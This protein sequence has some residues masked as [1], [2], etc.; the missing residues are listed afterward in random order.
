VY[1]IEHIEVVRR[2]E[3]SFNGQA[4]GLLHRFGASCQV[5]RATVRAVS[6]PGC[7][8]DIDR[9]VQVTRRDGNLGEMFRPLD[10]DGST[11]LKGQFDTTELTLVG[12]I[13]IRASLVDRAGQRV[14]VEQSDLP[15]GNTVGRGQIV[16]AGSRSQG[17]RGNARALAIDPPTVV[18][19]AQ[20]EGRAGDVGCSD[21]HGDCHALNPDHACIRGSGAASAGIEP[22]RLDAEAEALQIGD[23]LAE[24]RRG[25]H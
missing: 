20:Y 18:F 1:A 17:C 15:V 5:V 13:P 6:A 12:R 22:C 25:G 19:V 9:P 10:R 7:E 11:R 8:R 21:R 4:A 3:L 14:E 24:I 16:E 2:L 23:Q